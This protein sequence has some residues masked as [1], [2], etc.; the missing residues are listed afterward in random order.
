MKYSVDRLEDELVILVDEKGAVKEVPKEALP[1]VQ[2][3]DI[4]LFDG[5][6]YILDLNETEKKRQESRSLIDALFQ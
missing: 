5:D 2:E 1:V 6:S 4:L 3:G